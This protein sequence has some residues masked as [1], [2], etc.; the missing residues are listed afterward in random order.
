MFIIIQVYEL[1]NDMMFI[2]VGDKMVRFSITNTGHNIEYTT[3]NIHN[4]SK[5]KVSVK[6]CFVSTILTTLTSYAE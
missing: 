5:N 2:C 4:T 3:H 1:W 6:H